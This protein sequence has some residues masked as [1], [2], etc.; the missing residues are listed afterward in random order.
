[1][2]IRAKINNKL[3]ESLKTKD[4]VALAT[5]RLIMAAL[6]DRDI[7][8]RAAG[9]SEG[10]SDSEIMAMLQTMM[11][12][13]AESAAT[14]EQADR[15]DLAEREKAEIVVIESFMP[16]QLGES[17]LQTI[18][19]DVIQELGAADIKAMGK[20]MNTLKDR[21]AGQFDVGKASGVVK[22][23]LS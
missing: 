12:Q 4:Q 9:K 16:N 15:M 21:Y 19:Q 6:K 22:G 20:V 11:K 13:R 1:M 10:I 3:K 5:V 23:L 2:D 7:T 18:I 8:A 17:Q 14:Y